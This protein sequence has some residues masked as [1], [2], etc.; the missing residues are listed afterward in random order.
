ML[1]AFDVRDSKEGRDKPE[2]LSVYRI[3]PYKQIEDII[4]QSKALRRLNYK[5]QV[6]CYPENSPY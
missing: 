5:T 2:D 3:N 4:R 1:K 6:L